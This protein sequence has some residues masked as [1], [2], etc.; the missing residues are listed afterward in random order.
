MTERRILAKSSYLMDSTPS[1]LM[2]GDIPEHRTVPGLVLGNQQLSRPRTHAEYLLELDQCRY[3]YKFDPIASS[4]IN[5][6]TELAITP[7]QNRYGTAD[8]TERAYY[9]ALARGL[10]EMLQL[11]AR[12]FLVGGYALPSYTIERLMANRIDPSLGRNRLFIPGSYWVRNQEFIELKRSPISIDR[13]AYIKISPA[14]RHFI[15]NNGEY[16]DGTKDTKAYE[17]FARAFPEYVQAVK[18]ST[19]ELIPLQ[20]AHV[21]MRKPMSY[22]DYPQPY[23]VPALGSL[24]HKL[25]IKQM[26]YSIATRAL[27]AIR[28]IKVGNDEFPVEEGDTA[29]DDLEN[30][31]AARQGTSREIIY[32]LF[33]NHTVE[34]DWIYPPLDALLSD[35]KYSEPNS[36]IFLA[37]GFSR[38][39]LVGESLRSNASQNVSASLGPIATINEMREGLLKW[40][41]IMYEDM[42]EQN[43]FR[44]IPTPY[45]RPISSA[46]LSTLMAFAIEAAKMGS[47]S[48]DTIANAFGTTYEF[49]KEQRENEDPIIPDTPAQQPG[50]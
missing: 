29:L 2:G 40:I 49:E 26:D 24:R 25:R 3:F 12:E 20:H 16:P 21:I 31:I 11:A 5:R 44:N 36:D 27:E 30:K 39:L 46:D 6:M 33:T 48:Q 35:M 17:S 28:H 32:S 9:K 13:R 22:D 38:T 50:V 47:I 42:A 4:V 19:D 18:N 1:N 43:G 34:V 41:R 8:K 15:M 14:E 7:V 37:L 10:T 23:L 45:F